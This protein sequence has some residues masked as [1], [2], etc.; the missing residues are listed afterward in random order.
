MLY[1]RNILIIKV[2]CKG[3]YNFELIRGNETSPLFLM[4]IEDPC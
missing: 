4:D 1:I 2:Y 3:E